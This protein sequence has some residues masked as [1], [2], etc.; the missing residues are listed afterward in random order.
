MIEHII[1][2]IHRI[3]IEIISRGK[4]KCPKCKGIETTSLSQLYL[5]PTK[6]KETH[7]NTVEYYLENAVRIQDESQIP[8]G[9]QSCYISVLTCPQCGFKEVCINDFLKVREDTML[10]NGDVYPYEP[11]ENFLY[12][13]NF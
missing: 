8:N 2:L 9:Q 7:P 11:F 10:V 12:E 13:N 6:F 1:R 4:D 5:I 3:Y